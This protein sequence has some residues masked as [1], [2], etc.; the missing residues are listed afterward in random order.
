MGGSWCGEPPPAR[1]LEHSGRRV[2]HLVIDASPMEG[3]AS[4]LTFDPVVPDGEVRHVERRTAEIS[5][6][7]RWHKD[8]M[9]VALDHRPEDRNYIVYVVVEERLGLPRADLPAS[10]A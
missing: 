8:R 4:L 3:N 5:Y 2:S 6:S 7:L 9:I 1:L 10:E